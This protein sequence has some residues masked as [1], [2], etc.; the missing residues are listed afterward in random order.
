MNFL[1]I[2][3]PEVEILIATFP[4]LDHATA[5]EPHDASLCNYL[6][7]LL[8]SLKRHIN[9]NSKVIKIIK[10]LFSSTLKTWFIPSIFPSHFHLWL[11]LLVASIAD[12]Q[13]GARCLCHIFIG[14]QT[15]FL[16]FGEDSLIPISS[17]S[18]KVPLPKIILR[19]RIYSFTVSK[20]E[21]KKLMKWKFS[22][23]YIPMINDS[24][25]RHR[26]HWGIWT[27]NLA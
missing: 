27:I 6:E 22:L 20:A 4:I 1:A 5:L 9:Q 14:I 19:I 12:L 11:H 7:V 15:V 23:E 10:F 21:Q 16:T 24:W 18:T 25:L 8:R 17:R 3:P 13:F 26:G 2:L